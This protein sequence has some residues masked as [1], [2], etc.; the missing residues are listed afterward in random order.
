MEMGWEIPEIYSHDKYK[1]NIELYIHVIWLYPFSCMTALSTTSSGSS[2]W[3]AFWNDFVWASV[4]RGQPLW[5]P[6]FS[7]KILNTH[8]IKPHAGNIRVCL[9]SFQG[10]GSVCPQKFDHTLES[11]KVL[12]NWLISSGEVNRAGGWLTS[13][14]AKPAENSLQHLQGHGTIWLMGPSHSTAGTQKPAGHLSPGCSMELWGHTVPSR[15]V[16]AWE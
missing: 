5:S 7:R 10:I 3:A 1:S 13:A 16:Q 15:L 11:R 8:P 12:F 4:V 6:D 9:W 14:I 2:S